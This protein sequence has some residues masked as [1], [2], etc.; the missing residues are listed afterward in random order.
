MRA[1]MNKQSKKLPQETF[2]RVAD[3]IRVLG[4]AKRLQII[5][6]LDLYGERSVGEIVVGVGGQQSAVSQH[7]IKMRSAGIISVRRAG[8]Q[9]FYTIAA[10]SP[11]T[12][13]NC[14]RSQFL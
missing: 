7:L 10:Q 13:L 2:T 12:I 8:R 6:Y 1:T 3:A 9:V 11:I 14:I 4:H 5:E